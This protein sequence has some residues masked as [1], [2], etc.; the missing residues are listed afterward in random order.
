MKYERY[1]KL[2]ATTMICMMF[3]CGCGSSQPKKEQVK[4]M[5]NGTETPTPSITYE[6]NKNITFDGLNE[7]TELSIYSIDSQS[8]QVISITAMVDG[9]EKI[10]PQIIVD[11]VVEA[12]G[13]VAVTIGIDSVTTKDSAVIV[14]FQEDQPPVT[15]VDS[16]IEKEILDA[17]AQSLIDNL[18]EYNKVIYRVMGKAYTSDHITM[19]LDE[20]YM[21]YK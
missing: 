14:S 8:S 19:G 4:V 21:Q 13:D 15:D 9:E 7:Q 2:I 12:M 10:T 16:S 6:T 20:I 1:I 17:I 3:V 5:E 18:P 11:K